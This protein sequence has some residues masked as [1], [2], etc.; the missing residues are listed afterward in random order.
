LT[1]RRFSGWTTAGVDQSEGVCGVRQKDTGMLL[2]WFIAPCLPSP[3]DRVRRGPV[4]VHEIKLDGFWLMA[5]RDAAGERLI[6]RNGHNWS[7][8]FPL[9]AE[10]LTG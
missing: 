1:W 2:R 9:I 6:T 3:A 5:R 8:R 4:W 7:E 10:A